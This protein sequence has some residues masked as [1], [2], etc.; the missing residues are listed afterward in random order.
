MNKQDY[1][2][3]IQLIRIALREQVKKT[4][5]K[6]TDFNLLFQVSKM[7]NIANLI[8]YAIEELEL[9]IDKELYQE[10]ENIRD[11]EIIKDTMQQEEYKT[12]ISKFNSSNISF[13]TLKGM[14]IKDLYPETDMRTMGDIDFLI[15]QKDRAK[16]KKIME[17]LGYKT[18]VF[19]KNNEDIYHKLPVHNIEI[20]TELF[21]KKSIYYNFYKNIWK[22]L[23]KKEN[24][25]NE[26]IMTNEDFYV[27]LIA[28]LAKHYFHSGAGLRNII[29][30]YLFQKNYNKTLDLKY[31]ESKLKEYNLYEFEQD[32][33]SLIQVLFYNKKET[34]KQLEMM[35]FI[36]NSGTY[37]FS[38]NAYYNKMKQY[39]T[40]SNYILH[41]I[42]LP[43]NE[44]KTHYPILNKCILLLPILWIYRLLINLIKSPKS[45]YKEIQHLLKTQFK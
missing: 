19:N 10:W 1:N 28:H 25:S 43:I 44:M 32:L 12:I 8:F 14:I 23:L 41:R 39:K 30:I 13:I 16:A 38:E 42:F 29:D 40:K 35:N 11:Q 3:L 2:S 26:Y 27:F 33:T 5:F 6:N 21:E 22:N 37:G 4:T 7:H 18:E 24:T 9:D 31:I 17:E 20:H 36:L 45:I 34:S 15:K